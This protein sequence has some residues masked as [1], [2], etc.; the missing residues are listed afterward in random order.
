MKN[1]M[2]VES[3]TKVKSIEKFLGPDF[4]VIAS[5]GH[6]RDLV[7]SARKGIDVDQGFKPVWKVSNNKKTVIDDIKKFTK[8]ADVIYFAT[9]PDREGEAISK[10][11]Y[12]ILDK[13]KIL[14]EKETHRVV[15]NE[16]TK[17]AVTE[18][19]KKPRSI[20]TS[21]WDAY[22]ARRT[23]DY[24][25]GYDISEFLWKKV[26]RDARAGRVQSPALRLIVEREI[27]INAFIP[28]E[29][30]NITASISNSQRNIEIDLSQIKG[31]KVKKDNIT[32]INDS[33]KADEIKSMI[34]AH[35][36]VKVSNIKH[37]QRKTK[38]RAPFTTASLQ[39]TAYTSLGLSVRQ[40]SAIAQRLYQGMDIGSGQP[41]GLI[42]Y[43]R[44]DSTSLSK[45]ALDDI[46]S[47]LNNNH[48]GLASDEVRVYKGKTKNAQEAHEAIR[49][50]SMSNTPDK[51][52][53]YLE[54]ND[55]RLYDLIWKRALASQMKDSISKTVSIDLLAED[56]FVFKFSGS[57]LYFPGFKEVYS[58]GDNDEKERENKKILESLK[59]NDE[60]NI[61][62]VKT[63]QK[64][65]QPPARYNQASLI[66][67]LEEL[68]I[69]RPST[70]VT[71]IN[72]IMESNYVDPDKS[73]FQP[74]ALAKVVYET[75]IN[76]FKNDLVDYDFTARLEE[77]LDKI[78]NGE[79]E[80]MD[81]VEKTYKPFKNNLDDKIKTVDISEQR[82][83]KDLGVHPETNRPVTVRLTRYGPT[84][85]MGTKDDEE[86]PKWAAL[87]PEQK[88]NIDAITLDDAI[89]LFK[90]PEKIGEFE[91][92]DILI[93]IGPFGPYVKC[94]KTNVS[95]KE[96]D[97][98]ALSEQE[99]IS[100]IEEKREI[101]A[102]R[103]IKIFESSGIKVLNG[104]YGP[105]ITDG[106]K[107]VRVPKDIE[108]QS[109]DENTCIEMIKNAPKR[110]ARRARAKR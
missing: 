2:I 16:I 65:T 29:F 69:G 87:T 32:I 64:F 43:M 17:N 18:A 50:T 40:T 74:T 68:G 10:H 38:P 59:I 6:V 105:Y 26:S 94:G 61:D 21:L 78:A 57:Y 47:Y 108:P 56:D 45:D 66:Q 88:K 41:E 11:L 91:G 30:W 72:K 98:F 22:L 53:K 97:I 55:Y 92:E 28:E 54:E 35:D 15:F 19:L 103:E 27:K 102:N 52:K 76:H 31:E 100:R 1:L 42:S 13:A 25:M 99:A 46:S 7:S 70:Y 84:I 85:Q 58:I 93:N 101:D 4:K 90:L 51:I 20:S 110:R 82:E 104:M 60:L 49:P 14:K 5:V 86:K 39:Q 48:Q 106:K 67:A 96:I 33:K 37:G 12:D 89:R 95:M 71:I 81:C 75:L 83:L 79:K 23:L 36:K 24:L 34:E 62:S 8:D 109:L 73:N 80:Y 63:E 107:N 3:P 77:D 44:T 9:D